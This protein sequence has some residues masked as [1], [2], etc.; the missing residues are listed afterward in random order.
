MMVLFSGKDGKL[1]TSRKIKE[2]LDKEL[3]T[4]VSLRVQNTDQADRWKLFARGE[5]QIAVLAEQMRR[6]GYEF[7]Y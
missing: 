3:L 4:N 7:F 2:R 5:L 6:E 1:V